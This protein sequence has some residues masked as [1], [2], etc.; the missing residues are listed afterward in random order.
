M[1]SGD[2]DDSPSN[3]DMEGRG[4][5]GGG[6]AWPGGILFIKYPHLEPQVFSLM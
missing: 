5:G 2:S 4:G 3:A 1:A 6:G